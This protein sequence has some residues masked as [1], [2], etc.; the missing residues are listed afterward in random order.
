M[1][2]PLGLVKMATTILVDIG[3]II[4]FAALFASLARL[5]KQP[6]MLGYVVAGLVIG[7]VFG[8]LKN[9][10]LILT[11]SELGITFL[12]FIVGLELNLNKLKEVGK[13][14]SVITP[15]Q[16]ILITL[17]G[18]ALASLWVGKI[19]ALYIGLIL[20][21]SSTMVVVKLISDKKQLDTLHGRIVVGV[22]LVQDLLVVLA[23][24]LLT[25]FSS[26]EPVTML[27]A[28]FKALGLIAVAFVLHQ[29]VFNYIMRAS[30]KSPELLFVNALA[31][32]F[33]FAGLAYIL[34]FSIAIGAFIAGVSLASF[35]YNL[36]I[37][38][39]VKSL[40]DFFAV[41]FFVSLGSQLTLENIPS[42]IKVIMVLLVVVLLIKPIVIFIL[43]KASRYSNRTSLLS[44][45]SLAQVSEFS[46]VIAALGVSMNHISSQ[47]FD[48]TVVT[49]IITI[50]LTSYIIKY[51]RQIYHFLSRLLAPL[52]MLTHKKG[53]E[54]TPK[55]MKDHIVVFGVHRMGLKIVESLR[56]KKANFVVVDFNPDII[57]SLARQ[58]VRTVYGD[59]ANR[60]LLES[61]NLENA[62]MI[63]STIPDVDGNMV[64][65]E[66]A[67]M[68][69]KTA[70][71]FVT[72][73]S[74]MEA[75]TLYDAGA[76]FVILPDI[77]AG[78]KVADY[79]VHLNLA[80]IKKWGRFYHNR[81]LKQKKNEEFIW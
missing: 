41:I 45:I 78:Q 53:L 72:A 57:R 17:I 10:S 71:V 55:P 73:R 65:T 64:L 4:F 31:I 7:P 21:F 58:K 69:K 59:Y 11:L 6:L 3:I 49:A 76:D 47:T 15:I 81:I 16:V 54:S 44:A 66:Y 40:R 14:V 68:K 43:L 61:L 77:I 75:L 56:N 33:I 8:I 62:K 23:L 60:E 20:A 48:M 32:C 67:R 52:E 37:V 34:G 2:K 25:T 51:D 46:L 5:L 12:L 36:E 50:L 35:P 26:F 1:T 39:R 19:E 30:A 63:I 13:L 80:G 24:P 18:Y 70:M 29:F 79:M 28:V 22:L 38:G 27:L 42:L 9:Q 74:A